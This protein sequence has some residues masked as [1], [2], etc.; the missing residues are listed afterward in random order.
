MQSVTLLL[1]SHIKPWKDSNNQERLNPFNG[2]LLIPD[3][4]FLFDKGY[5]TFKGNGSMLV[6]QRLSLFARKVFDVDDD[7][8][9]RNVFP[10]NK[11][12]LDFH[13]S[14]VFE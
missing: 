14:E 11:E 10:E 1:S 6:S 13:R 7:L 8:Q 9:L 3:Y 2:L 4:D 12:Y 5:I